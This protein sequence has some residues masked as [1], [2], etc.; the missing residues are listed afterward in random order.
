VIHWNLLLTPPLAGAPNMALDEALLVRARATGEGVVRV[1]SWSAPTISVGRHQSAVG[2]WDLT[3]LQERGVG[4]VRRLTGGR[5]ILHHREITYSVTAPTHPG[6]GLRDDYEAITTLLRAGLRHLGVEATAATPAGR[7]PAPA[8]APCFELPARDELVLE[9]RKLV[10]SAQVREDGAFLQHGSLLLH[11]D[12]GILGELSTRP[13]TVSPAATLTAAVGHEVTAAEF[14]DA[15]ELQIERVWH[16]RPRRM[17]LDA[18]AD[19]PLTTR[20]DDPAWTWL[21]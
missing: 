21:R 9:G 8:S 4:I 16:T 10:A 17:H 6:T 11:D 19:L 15:L 12:Q 5:A 20:Y 18:C 13:M 3:R 1:Y 2:A 14:A 7:L